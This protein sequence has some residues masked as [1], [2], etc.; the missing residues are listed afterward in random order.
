MSDSNDIKAAANPYAQLKK[1]VE[2]GN[3]LLRDNL[4]VNSDIFEGQSNNHGVWVK[5]SRHRR[6]I[7]IAA[8]LVTGAILWLD[9]LKLNP[10]S[11]IIGSFVGVTRVISG[12]FL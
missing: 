9:V 2:E 12:L 4:K 6:Y 8:V 10:D 5:V 3:Q 11:E 7:N 1:A